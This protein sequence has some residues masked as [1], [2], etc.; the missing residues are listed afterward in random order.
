VKDVDSIQDSL[1]I[2]CPS[3]QSLQ[4]DVTEDV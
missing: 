1:T 2:S 4:C 3:F